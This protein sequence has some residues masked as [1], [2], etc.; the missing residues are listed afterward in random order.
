MHRSF[1]SGG[2]TW[3][4]DFCNRKTIVPIIL[5]ALGIGSGDLCLHYLLYR[6]WCG[7]MLHSHALLLSHG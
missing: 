6:M 1:L 7:E 5:R 3:K 4:E 2:L